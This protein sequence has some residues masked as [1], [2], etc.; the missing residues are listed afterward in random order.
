MND[1]IA[2]PK[3]TKAQVPPIKSC[4]INDDRSVI[5]LPTN[6]MKKKYL[7]IFDPLPLK[8]HSFVD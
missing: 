6:T 3:D 1:A 2:S 5:I 4:H 7:N 8:Y